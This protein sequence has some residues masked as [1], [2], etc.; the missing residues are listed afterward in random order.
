MPEFPC[1]S[2]GS[3][4]GWRSARRASLG[5][6]TGARFWNLAQSATSSVALSVLSEVH[7]LADVMRSNALAVEASTNSFQLLTSSL[8]LKVLVLHESVSTECGMC[9]PSRI[10]TVTQWWH[11]LQ[12]PTRLDVL[13]VCLHSSPFQALEPVLPPVHQSPNSENFRHFWVSSTA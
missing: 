7:A 2:R 4:L 12:K 9:S 3:R 13:I 10:R 8:L 11:R 5:A 1:Q 6:W